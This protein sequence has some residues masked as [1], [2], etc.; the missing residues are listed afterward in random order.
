MTKTKTNIKTK[1]VL[2][3][4]NVCRGSRISNMTFPPK[5]FTQHFLPEFFHQKLFTQ[6]FPPKKFYQKLPTI[7]YNDVIAHYMY[8]M[9]Y[10]LVFS[11]CVLAAGAACCWNPAVARLSYVIANPARCAARSL[12][13]TRAC[14]QQTQIQIE[15]ILQIHIKETI[16]YYSENCIVVS[17]AKS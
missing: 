2:Q 6:Y 8:F 1:T 9:L 13:H 4:P 10:W 7:K 11:I 16:I 5:N 14:F 12:L 3:I 15:I 17:H